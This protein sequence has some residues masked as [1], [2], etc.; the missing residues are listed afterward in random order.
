MK[1]MVFMQPNHV[2]WE[3]HKVVFP[4]ISA[5]NIGTMHSREPA[6]MCY[7]KQFRHNKSVVLK[8]FIVSVAV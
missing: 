4:A 1:P 3:V 2:S 6:W 7:P 8:E 5:R